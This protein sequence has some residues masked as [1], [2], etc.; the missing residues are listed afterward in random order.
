LKPTTPDDVLELLEASTVS[1]ALGAAMELGLFWLLEVRPLDAHGIASA[2]DIPLG[3]CRYWLQLLADAGLVVEGRHGYEPSPTAKTAI[4]EIFE[5]DSWALL[6]EEARERLRGLVDLPV[7]MRV[8]GSAWTVM[9][10]T[11]PMYLDHLV[12][13]PERARRFTRMLAD[14]HEPLAEVVV[15]AVD[16]E[17][18]GRLMDLGGGSGVVSMAALRRYPDLTATVVDVANVCIAGRE[19]AAAASLQDRLTYH[20]ADFLH[21]EL[22]AD[23]DVI[24]EC[25][26]NIYGVELFRKV[27]DSLC[28]GGRFVIVDQLAPAEGVA[29]PSRVHWAF[30][31]AL[32]DPEFTFPTAA[33]IRAQ[34]EG[35]GF[36]DVS[37]RPLPAVKGP[38]KRFAVGTVVI[39]GTK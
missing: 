7:H 37:E 19:I 27:R 30:A 15:D 11:P 10:L 16:L 20:P 26:V 1:A 2:L 23:F 25:D 18:A 33:G 32:V 29:P 13:D 34:L 36:R 24:L 35:A 6:A 14:L 5:Q 21:D 22:P 8:A 3:R 4:L 9:G 12:G 31:G 38:G 17:A 28:Q 39:E